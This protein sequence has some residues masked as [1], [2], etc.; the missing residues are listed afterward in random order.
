MKLAESIMKGN[1]CYT[2]GR[3]ITVKGLMLH[4]V[5]CPQPD[6]LTF[7]RSWNSPAHGSS[8]VHGFIDGNDGTA[9]QTLPWNRRG[10]HCGSGSRG[11]GNNTHI[12]VEMCE[13][14][15]IHRA[16]NSPAPIW[17]RQRLWRNGLMRRRWSCSPC[18]VRSTALTRLQTASSS[19]IRKA[20]R[21]AL[22][23]TTVTR[24]ISGHS[25][26][27]GTPW[28]DSAGQSRRRWTGTGSPAKKPGTASG[29]DGQMR[30]RRKGHSRILPTQKNAQTAVRG[31]LCLMSPERRFT[32][33]KAAG[34]NP[35]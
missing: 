14:A 19:A 17:P 32:K 26:G 12:G 5:G 1:P 13:P 27:Q 24:S 20:V 8:C 21:G 30:P 6:A 11:S 34:N 15:C 23:L 33:G 28:T 16:V 10:W 22:P 7:I 31:I 2:A 29:K 4:S 3:K 18:S 35:A 9:Y 25:L